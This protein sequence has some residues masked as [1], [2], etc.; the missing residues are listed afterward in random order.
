V[1]ASHRGQ[2][3]GLWSGRPRRGTGTGFIVDNRGYIVTN[4]HVVTLGSSQVAS[5]LEVDLWD[6]RSVEGKLVGRDERTDLAVIKIEAGNLT[7]VRFAAPPDRQATTCWRS[8]SRSTSADADRDQGRCQRQGP[9]DRR[10]LT[11]GGRQY[12][13][14]ISGAI[15]T[16]PHQ[17]GNSGGPLVNMKGSWDQH[18]RSLRRGRPTGAGHLRRRRPGG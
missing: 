7:P 2:Q 13:V 5:T 3:T 1:R 17:P 9:R 14:S 12:G 4:N 6:G 15:Q 18:R 8:A 16:T 11:A 10:D